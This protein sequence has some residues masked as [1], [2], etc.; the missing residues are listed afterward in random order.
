MGSCLAGG[1]PRVYNEHAC[2]QVCSRVQGCA[3]SDYLT[4]R[5]IILVL[6][7]IDSGWLSGGT[8]QCWRRCWDTCHAKFRV[9]CSHPCK[10]PIL[11]GRPHKQQPNVDVGC[12][13]LSERPGTASS[14]FSMA[15]CASNMVPCATLVNDSGAVQFIMKCT[16]GGYAIIHGFSSCC[17]NMLSPE[18]T[19]PEGTPHRLL[20]GD[21]KD[22][23]LGYTVMLQA[24]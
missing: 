15:S 12:G 6:E 23:H 16:C 13:D 14:V 9:Y 3:R 2:R 21:N 4:I 5:D 22:S 8:R 11:L 1:K 24:H 18:T 7:I 19:R 17:R 20:T 10:H